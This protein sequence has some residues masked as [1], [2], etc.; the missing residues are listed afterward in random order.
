MRATAL[1]SRRETHSRLLLLRTPY[2][3][4]RSRMYPQLMLSTTPASSQ[5]LSRNVV[6]AG[7]TAK[8]TWPWP[9]PWPWPWRRSSSMYGVQYVRTRDRVLYG[10]IEYL[11]L[12]SVS[13]SAASLEQAMVVVVFFSRHRMEKVLGPKDVVIIRSWVGLISSGQFGCFLGKMKVSLPF[14]FDRNPAVVPIEVDLND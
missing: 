5:H 14:S 11:R 10:T 4:V 1:A 7:G 13:P 9:W 3:I 2:S 12:Q 8:C 6:C